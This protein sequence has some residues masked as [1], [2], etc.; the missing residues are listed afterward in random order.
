MSCRFLLWLLLLLELVK[1]TGSF[2]SSLALLEKGHKPKR[3]CRYCFVGLCK[4]KLMRLG[5]HEK[6]WFAFLLRC[7][8]LYCLTEVAAIKVAEELHSAPHKLMH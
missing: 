3:V 1:D 7:G 5:L 6:D 4:L 2:I 8:Q